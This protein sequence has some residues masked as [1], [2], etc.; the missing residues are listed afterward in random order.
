MLRQHSES[1]WDR[2]DLT[3]P[4]LGLFFVLLAKVRTGSGVHYF[5]VFK[6]INIVVGDIVNFL[7]CELC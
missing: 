1:E 6:H 3:A 7:A 2:C 4:I 5:P